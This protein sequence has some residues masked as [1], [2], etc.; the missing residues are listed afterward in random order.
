MHTGVPERAGVRSMALRR[1]M[2]GAAA[3]KNE[4][5]GEHIWQKANIKYGSGRIGSRF[6]RD[7]PETD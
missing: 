5:A 3:I 2:V 6:L 1:G 7:G 4:K